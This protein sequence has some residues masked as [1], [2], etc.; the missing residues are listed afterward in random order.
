MDASID[1]SGEW[2]GHYEQ[3]G[4]R[5]AIRMS[6]TQLGGRLHGAMSDEDTLFF[7]ETPDEDGDDEQDPAGAEPIQYA[8]SLPS[9]SRID[10]SVE[11]A[12]VRFVKTYEGEHAVD[13][14][15]GERQVRVVFEGHAVVY[16]GRVAADGRRIE[17]RWHIGDERDPDHD[18]GSFVLER[19]I[20][21][22]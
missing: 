21:P 1:L 4:G 17:G 2:Q 9:T 11:G 15:N 12:E 8:S 7:G 20:G 6:V 22:T 14:W 16:A 10:G 13:F 19:A 18:T 5:H 3:E